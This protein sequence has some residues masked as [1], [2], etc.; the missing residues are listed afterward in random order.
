MICEHTIDTKTGM[1]KG[2]FNKELIE[3]TEITP[4]IYYGRRQRI[5]W[6]GHFMREII[7]NQRSYVL[8][9]NRKKPTRASEKKMD[10]HD[11]GRFKKERITS[12]NPSIMKIFRETSIFV[13]PFRTIHIVF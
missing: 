9:T 2:K 7:Y 8:K 5:Q 1:W 10:G 4:I 11:Q 12:S 3:E 6:F 13:I